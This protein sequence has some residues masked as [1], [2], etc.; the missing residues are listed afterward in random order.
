GAFGCTLRAPLLAPQDAGFAEAARLWN[1]MVQRTPALV[2]QPESASDVATAIAFARDHGVLLGV[3]GGGHNIAG[4]AVPERGLVLDMSRM[5]GIVVEPDA[6]LAHVEPG[7]LLGDVDR[8]TQEHGLATVLGFISQVGVAGLTLGGGL[9]Y[10]TR[11]FG[12]SVDN[13]EQAEIVT[14]DGAVRVADR[15]RNADLFWALRGAGANFGVVTRLTFRL[16]EVGP[17]VHGGLIAWPFERAD[18]ILHAYREITEH[19][20]RE[21]AAWLVLLRAPQ[22]PFV[23]EQ[24]HGRRLAGMAVC[25][26]GDLADADA[27]L[28]PIRALGTPVVDLLAPQPYTEVQSYLDASEPKGMH[29]YWKTEYLAG[30]PDDLLATLHE[31]YAT[32]PIPDGDM[33]V[34]HLDGALNERDS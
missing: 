33:G 3:R 23:P 10:L 2:A 28:A 17:T 22:A 32:C 13:L 21:L 34:L 29:Y 25:Y 27:A 6:G 24:W 20:P 16:H 7:C 9:G 11:R 19:A 30:L 31:L 12:W 5:C 8:A 14:A 18:E 1:G 26:S 15:Q 4:S